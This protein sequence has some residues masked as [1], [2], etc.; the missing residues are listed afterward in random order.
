M[1]VLSESH[2]FYQYHEF[3]DHPQN[4]LLT[5]CRLS[6]YNTTLILLAGKCCVCQ[7]VHILNPS[8]YHNC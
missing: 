5:R 4:L 7:E 6:P 2:R 8:Y 3:G 1:F